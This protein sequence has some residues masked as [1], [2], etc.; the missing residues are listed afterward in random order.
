MN[1][2]LIFQASKV[3]QHPSLSENFGVKIT[4]VLSK[5]VVLKND[6]V[7]VFNNLIIEL[8]FT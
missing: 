6:K 4:M 8:Q 3:L 2:V 1:L 7:R 5:L